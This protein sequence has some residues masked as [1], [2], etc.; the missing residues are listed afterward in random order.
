MPAVVV[1]PQ[2]RNSRRRVAAR[3]VLTDTLQ[4]VLAVQTAEPF[5]RRLREGVGRHRA[6]GYGMLLLRPPNDR[7]PQR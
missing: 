1:Q 2:P 4:G 6:Y 5:V 3:R 7:P